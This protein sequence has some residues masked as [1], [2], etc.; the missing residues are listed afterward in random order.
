MHKLFSISLYFVSFLPLWISVLFID[1]LSIVEKQTDIRTECI[2]IFCILIVMFVSVIV[3]YHDLHKHGREGSKSHTI[4]T[5]RE[6]KS[7]TAEFLLSYILPLF[8]FDFTL[9][10]QVVLFLI[11][12]TTLGFLCIRHNYYSVNIVLEIVGYRFFRCNMC[13]SDNV[14]TKQLIISKQRLNE[15]IGTDIYVVALNNDYGLDVGKNTK[16]Q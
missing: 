4:K 2:S 11:F 13:N 9:W 15:L 14:K 12:F 8:A 1:I 16:P 10:N 3:I 7:I 5:A 6:E